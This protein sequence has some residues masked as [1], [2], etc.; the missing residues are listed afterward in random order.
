MAA[1]SPWGRDAQT[2]AGAR[3]CIGAVWRD[4]GASAT[5]SGFYGRSPHI[6]EPPPQYRHCECSDPIQGRANR[7]GLLRVVYPEQR[8]LSRKPKGSQ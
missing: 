5:G 6:V 8:L 3:S 4:C 2:I 7:P 1:V